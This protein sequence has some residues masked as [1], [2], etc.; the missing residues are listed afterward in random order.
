MDLDGLGRSRSSQSSALLCTES[1]QSAKFGP[2]VKWGQEYKE[3]SWQSLCTVP[4]LPRIG[5]FLECGK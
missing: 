2:R 4:A 1:W 5:L 3:T